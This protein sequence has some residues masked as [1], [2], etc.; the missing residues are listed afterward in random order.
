[1]KLKE[2]V[3][4]IKYTITSGKYLPQKIFR[5]SIVSFPCP[6][7]NNETEKIDSSRICSWKSKK[8][9]TRHGGNQGTC[10]EVITKF[11]K[12]LADT[13]SPKQIS[14]SEPLISKSLNHC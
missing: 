9:A 1:M 8:N 5:S 7:K 3:M 12:K 14:P 13:T 2:F 6:P 11:C 10:N 4:K